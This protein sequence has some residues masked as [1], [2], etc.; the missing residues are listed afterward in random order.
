MRKKFTH[1][2]ILLF[3]SLTISNVIIAKSNRPVPGLSLKQIKE[4]INTAS[5][6]R[7]L[8]HIRHLTLHHRWFV[9]DGYHEAALYIQKKAKEIG[10]LDV[11][12]EKF[13]ADGNIFYSTSKSL[14]KWTVRSAELSLVSPVKKHLVSWEENPISLA[15][16][17]RS[18]NVTAELVDVGEGTHPSDYDAKDVNGKLVLASSPQGGGRI[19]LVH[20]L[21]VLERGAAGVISYRSYHLDDFPDLITWDHINTRKLNG[22]LS[23]FGFCISKRM[24][25]ELQRLLQKGEKFV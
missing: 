19:D 2:F 12:I 5:G 23:T 21:A 18:A 11:K 10:L 3:I 14:P 7:A 8:N 4:I 25:W 1:S 6:E 9:S 13:L 24:G 15:S 20:R 16:Y 22:K 17:S